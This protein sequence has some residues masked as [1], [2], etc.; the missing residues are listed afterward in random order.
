MGVIRAIIV[1][2]SLIVRRGESAEMQMSN[3]AEKRTHIARR[4]E[5]GACAAVPR[6]ARQ[7]LRLGRQTKEVCQ[8][9]PAFRIQG[10]EARGLEVLAQGRQTGGDQFRLAVERIV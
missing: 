6:P 10:G 8:F 9:A 4:L 1:S 7:P 5:H 3:Y 2:D